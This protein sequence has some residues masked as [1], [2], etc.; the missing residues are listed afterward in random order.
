MRNALLLAIVPFSFTVLL[1][2]PG[3]QAP[4]APPQSGSAPAPVSTRVYAAQCATCHG[5][6]MK[7]GTARSI[8]PYVR[9]H[10]N[11]EVTA[12]MRTHT[13][14]IQLPE[15]EQRELL[16][17]LRALAGTNPTM[18]TGGYTGQRG[19]EGGGGRG[20]GGFPGRGGRGRGVAPS[21][22][23]P[24]LTLADGRTITGKVMATSESDATVL[25]NGR[26]Y[27]LSRSGD[28][29]REK[30]IEPKADWL[31]YDGSYTGNR[32]SPLN[33]INAGNV[34]KLAP[35]WIFPI[36]T[37]TRLE[38]TPVV[39]DGIMYATGWNE[40][41]ALDA[42]T[43]RQLWRYSEA[44]HEGILG[45]A[46]F[47]ANRGA[48]IG[49][50]KV[51][52]VTDHAHVLA[53]NRFTGEKLWDAA[54][55]SHEHG[56]SA[57]AAPLTIGDLVVV[58]VAG[59]EEGAR[60]FIDAYRAA[61]GER[62]W[63]FWTIPARGEKGSETWSGQAI[64]HGCGATWLTGSYDPQLDL[65]Y[66]GV[67]NPCPD[68]TGDERKGDN[69]Y[70]ASVVALSAKTGELKW[71][72]QFTPHDTH[73]W[74]STQPMLLVD[75][76]WQGRPRKLLLHGDRNGMFY[77]LDRAT[78]E[79]LLGEKLSAKVTWV[80]G[81]EKNGRP[82]VDEGS[83]A[84]REGVAACPGSN[85]GANW[86][87]A[88][89]SPLTKLFYTRV[90]DSCGVYAS[91]DDPLG[92][93]GNRW[94]GRG[95]AGEKAREALQALVADSPSGSFIRALDPFT[96]KK[97]WD[98]ATPNSRAGLLGTAGGMIFLGAEGGLV[99][100]DPKSGKSLWNINLGQSSSA[101][102]MTYMVGGRQYIALPGVGL[103][104]AYT[105]K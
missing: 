16:T 64:D 56:Y 8:V 74:D 31:T 78:G 80:K 61:T 50:D 27:L 103:L 32:Y 67:G 76:P 60:G 43:G 26:Y 52:M 94:F 81:F 30:P 95:T 77:V 97:V 2:M 45:E 54:M 46:G 85:G 92:A 3:A 38:V 65:T 101:S 70:T 5:T 90:L 17:E 88:S 86:T 24:T 29:Y 19:A 44:R 59:G 73:D 23:D 55:A 42:T 82:I 21:D 22:S 68:Y 35:A 63:R 33:Q 83:I 48:A 10:N 58:G 98:Y 25:A 91:S 102:P 11:A 14:P 15:A 9:Y 39:A 96:G 41:Y 12:V 93:S 99:A 20:R 28:V 84:T 6:D 36:P 34:Q 40:L 53:F 72:Y 89:Y 18:A 37:S 100:L 87:A 57:T 47:G 7:G 1:A 69:L 71:H 75:E 105:V 66:W 13:P 51:F 79:F 104:V 62:V 4:S 49:G